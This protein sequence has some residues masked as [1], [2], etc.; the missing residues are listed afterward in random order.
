MSCAAS[1]RLPARSRMSASSS[2]PGRYPGAQERSCS[3]S[4]SAPRRSPPSS[5]VSARRC[6]AIGS[7]SVAAGGGTGGAS[8]A[9]SA[10]EGARCPARRGRGGTRV[11]PPG[12]A[13]VDVEPW[14]AD[15]HE[16][17]RQRDR[18]HRPEVQHAVGSERRRDVRERSP[19]RLGGEVDEHVPAQ[20][21][22]E[23]PRERRLRVEEV[24]HLERWCAAA[25]TAT[26]PPSPLV[27]GRDPG[28][29]V[30]GWSIGQCSRM[31]HG[32]YSP[33]WAARTFRSRRSVPITSTSGKPRTA[34]VA[35]SEYAS[36]PVAHP[37]LQARTV[38]RPE[39]EPAFEDRPASGAGSAPA[40]GRSRSPRR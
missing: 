13:G 34:S 30:I 9:R 17:G 7:D 6:S 14:G 38:R 4:L 35:A 19:R 12:R 21:C 5:R 18:V 23:P 27:P 26:P 22:V 20:D 3:R 25:A 16:V 8:A 29:S 32:P 11:G 37:A 24:R 31:D 33:R 28:R 1:A 15:L 40:A 10:I 39:G 36:S 2:L